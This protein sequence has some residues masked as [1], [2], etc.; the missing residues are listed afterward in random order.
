MTRQ[1]QLEK[2]QL[3]SSLDREAGVLHRASKRP[4]HQCVMK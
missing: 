2:V 3:S 1:R 4:A